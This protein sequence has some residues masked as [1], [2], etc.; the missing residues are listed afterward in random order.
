M[1]ALA[2]GIQVLVDF[3]VIDFAAGPFQL[4][5]PVFGILDTG[6]LANVVLSDLTSFVKS[7]SI[8]RGRSRQLEQFNSGSAVVV[9]D[10]AE[11]LLDPLNED[12][13]FYPNVLPRNGLQITANGIPIFYG[14]VV[15]WNLSYDLSA[16]DEMVAV[17]SDD[18]TVLANQV[19]DAFTPSEELSGDRINTVLARPEIDYQGT[20][21]ISAGSYSLGDYA[22]NA[23]T[24]VLNYLQ[25][26]AKSEQGFLYVSANGVLTFKG[27]ADTLNDDPSFFFSDD[28]TGV[29][30]QTLL[31]Q[32]GDELLYN[33]IITESPAGGPFTASDLNSQVRFQYQQLSLTDLLNSSSGIVEEIGVTLLDKYKDPRLRLTGLTSQLAGFTLEQQGICLEID[34]TDLCTVKKT[35]VE[36]SPSSIEQTLLV[37]GISHQIVPG[38]HTITYVFESLFE[39]EE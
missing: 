6:T 16:Q 11:R 31:N 15:D 2:P 1:T 9:F 26:V 13:I 32:F 20:R 27:N 34:L 24:N 4:D 22:V 17:C 28:G 38:S 10:N 37:S 36:G 3:D 29:P 30:Y 35:F 19:L 7:I 14:L 21:L 12:S 18:F 5:D 25:L 33:Y 39:P 23:N 8:N